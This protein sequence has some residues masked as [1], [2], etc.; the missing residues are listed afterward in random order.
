M[1]R[2]SRRVTGRTLVEAIIIAAS[3]I[4]VG[5]WGGTWGYVV[6]AVIVGAFFAWSA[7]AQD[8][9]RRE[10]S[11]DNW[12]MRTYVP[13]ASRHQPYSHIVNFGSV[14]LGLALIFVWIWWLFGTTWAVAMT[15]LAAVGSVVLVAMSVYVGRRR[16]RR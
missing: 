2:F 10:A 13:W 3:G 9:K 1:Q 5:L 14:V 7:L 12:Y 8:R 16:A 15:G 4:A 11:Q 6:W